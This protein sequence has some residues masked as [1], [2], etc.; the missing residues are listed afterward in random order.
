MLQPLKLP[1]RASFLDSPSGPLCCVEFPAASAGAGVLVVA[2][3]GEEM[4]KCRRMMAL[5]A[6]ALQAAGLTTVLVDCHGTGDSAGDH[7]EATV[8]L[9]RL[10]LVRAV[11]RLRELGASPVHVLAIRSGALLP[12][13]TLFAHCGQ[14]R[15]CLWQPM[16]SGRQVVTQWLRLAA[17]GEVVSGADRGGEQ[18]VRE[19]LESRGHV[20]IAGY[21]VS[22]EFIDELEPLELRSVLRLGWAR[23]AWL[24]VAPDDAAPLTPAATRAIAAAEVPIESRAVGGE[25]FW[26]TP[27]IATADSLIL[28]TRDFFTRP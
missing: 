26:A 16:Q 1:V 20:E 11:Q 15:L 22:R 27:E 18:R 17:A 13:S 3:I 28:A 6:R 24:E 10:D 9:W 21:D 23:I 4:N 19:A 8:S 2:P 7:R 25:P 14:G 12:D 5:T